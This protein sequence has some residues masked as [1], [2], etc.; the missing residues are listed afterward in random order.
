VVLY[1]RR[2]KDDPKRPRIVLPAPGPGVARKS[3]G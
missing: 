2:S 1:K 3:A